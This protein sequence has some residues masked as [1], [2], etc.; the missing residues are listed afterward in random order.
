MTCMHEFLMRIAE[1][2]F[3]QIYADADATWNRRVATLNQMLS[4][5]RVP[6]AIANMHSILTILYTQ[7]SR[8][9]WMFQFYLRA[10][11]LELAWTGSGRLIMSLDYP[12]EDFEEV[13]N[14]IVSAALKMQ[15]DGWWWTAPHLTN[16]WI[17]RQMLRDMLIA[18][19]HGLGTAP[20]V[21]EPLPETHLET[22]R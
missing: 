9:N 4:D 21:P 6:V 2:E 14:R 15:G 8:Y 18:R 1:P 22:L 10:D 11:G 16:T 7:P 19:M 13:A 12:D 3:Q 5:A 20:A 17:K